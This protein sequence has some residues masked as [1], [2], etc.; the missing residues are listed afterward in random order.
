MGLCLESRAVLMLPPDFRCSLRAIFGVALSFWNMHLA[1]AQEQSGQAPLVLRPSSLLQEIITK[2]DAKSMPTFTES[3]SWQER[4]SFQTSMDGQVVMRR[5]GLL[6]KA[7]HLDYDQ[8]NDVAKAKGNVYVN[9]S[10]SV[11]Q[12][13][14][15]ELQL[16]G[17]EGFFTNPTYQMQKY[18]AHG[19]ADKAS[20][21]DETNTVL[22]NATYTTCSR[23][24]GPDWIPDWF[25]K[26]DEI[27]I[28]S[29]RSI[30]HVEGASLRFKNVPITPPI[31]SVDF[32][33]GDERKS[34]LLSPTIGTG[35][36]SGFEYSQPI[37]WNLAPN[38]DLTFTPMFWS[39]RGINTS[40]EFRYLDNDGKN[41]PPY[42]GQLRIDYMTDDKI[43]DNTAR[44]ATKYSH[45]G[46][47][48]PYVYGGTLGLNVNL[49]RASDHN[50]WKDFAFT[51][52]FG[53][54]RLLSNDALLS[55]SDGVFLTSLRVQKWQTLQ[56]LASPAARITAPFDRVPQ[57]TGRIQ[58]YN[59]PGGFDASLDGDFSRFESSRFQDCDAAR[60]QTAADASYKTYANC[61]PN[62]NRFVS[63]AQLSRPF[64][65]PY[66]YLTPKVQ[67][68]SRTY[69]F[70]DGL[71][72]V[73]F[74]SRQ[75]TGNYAGLTSAN[76]TVPTVSLDTSAVLERSAPL[77]GRNW[78]Q[79]LEPR[80]L[81]V[82]TPYREQNFLPNYDSG[83]YGFNL[84]SI[85]AENAYAGHDRVA[86]LTALTIGGTSR[87]ID[88]ETGA[89]GARFVLAQ[90]LRLADQNVTVPEYNATAKSGVTDILAGA[91][92]NLSRYW[93]VE[94]AVD[95]NPDSSVFMRRMVGGRYQ[96]GSYRLLSAAY[97]SNN[98]ET[99]TPISRQV[100]VGW[101]WPLHDLWKAVDQN[102]GPG[103]GLGE[104]RWYGVG[105]FNYDPSAGKVVD[106][107]IGFE[108]DA[109]CWV[110]RVVAEKVQIADNLANQRVLFQLEL[111]GMS[112]V[113]SNALTALRNS[114]PRYQPLRQ[115]TMAPSRFGN[116]D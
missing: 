112:R 80:L 84:A 115:P 89:E 99:G 63:V 33:I 62:A 100:E 44:W 95:Y 108:Y 34:G 45:S 32:P 56:D 19:R 40:T 86:D 54:Q 10:G 39:D 111:V 13:P 78:T 97:R 1:H 28:D 26:G 42:L 12:G 6:I 20:F 4:T 71:P 37:Y 59:L 55:W 31:P 43:R 69:Q 61:A 17:F 27:R 7:D 11:F 81:Y 113:G 103:Q 5:G 15:L 60:S 64:T 35:N 46:V 104:G 94:S 38:R 75:A 16:D 90:R 47:A 106:S 83:S 57:I 105:R 116:Y 82:Q 51:N 53:G 77:F 92:L 65:T 14:E 66:G 102:N 109:G 50:Y 52:P 58:K 91:S 72:N 41:A 68:H 73:G 25:F 23:K 8:T 110:S 74:Y 2:D 76:V 30:A 96:P 79:T 70:E 114:I 101:Q 93:A 24:P 21:L 3:N 67:L 9:R 18:K 49:N 36:S 29:E 88:N 87:F 107:L 98:N 85:F 22:Y 48:N